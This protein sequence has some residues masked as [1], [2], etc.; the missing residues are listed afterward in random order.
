M[1]V[2][3]DGASRH[4]GVVKQCL[5]G[6]TSRR[7]PAFRKMAEPAASLRT[8]VIPRPS[9]AA[10]STSSTTPTRKDWSSSRSANSA[11]SRA[12]SGWG[13]VRLVAC[14]IHERLKSC[15]W[16]EGSD[17]PQ[18]V[19][20][21]AVGRSRSTSERGR[22][23]DKTQA[24]RRT[25]KA[26][27]KTEGRQLRV[28]IGLGASNI[29]DR[30]NWVRQPPL[31]H[32]PR[33]FRLHWQAMVRVQPGFRSGRSARSVRSPD[34][35]HRAHGRCAPDSL[36]VRGHGQATQDHPAEVG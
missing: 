22:S 23:L 8:R 9:S 28:A 4:T 2:A 24:Y 19:S 30:E 25:M 3:V 7:P 15:G 35:F 33:S 6:E 5:N 17:A 36:V 27:L 34:Q 26:E 29:S 1:P 20:F 16:R 13:V 32:P 31:D 14:A 21:P 18:W 12:G 11:T 10:R